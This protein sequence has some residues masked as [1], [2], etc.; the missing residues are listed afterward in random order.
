MCEVLLNTDRARNGF[1]NMP[2]S[3]KGSFP[4]CELPILL[5]VKCEWQNVKKNNKGFP[6]GKLV[7]VQNFTTKWWTG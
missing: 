1:Q 5:P 6:T 7:W 3:R 4:I 2:Q